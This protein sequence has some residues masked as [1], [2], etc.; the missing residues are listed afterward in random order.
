MKTF[1]K[2]STFLFFS[3]KF[4]NTTGVNEND[5]TTLEKSLTVSQKLYIYFPL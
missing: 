4:H 2:W 3:L 5:I 1:E